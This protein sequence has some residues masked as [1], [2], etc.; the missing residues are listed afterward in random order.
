MA[1]SNGSLKREEGKY[2]EIVE[3]LPRLRFSE[4]I[5][6]RLMQNL[7]A[8]QRNVI[9]LHIFLRQAGY[10][11]KQRKY[12]SQVIIPASSYVHDVLWKLGY[13]PEIVE[14]AARAAEELQH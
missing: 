7:T 8:S 4:V 12:N 13:D 9:F 6:D 10:V 11:V 14:L 2:E 3:A 5:Y 1:H